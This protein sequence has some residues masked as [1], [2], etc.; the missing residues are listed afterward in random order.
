MNIFEQKPDLNNIVCHS[1]GATGADTYFETLGEIWGVKTHA[2]SYKTD[3]HTSKNK[4]EI[5]Q[6]DFE[7]GIEEI[8]KANKTLARFGIHKYMNLLARNWAQIK[9]SKQVFAI[10]EIINPRQKTSRGYYSK[11]RH[12]TVDGGTGYAVQMAIN[13][14]REV[15]VYCQRVK[16]WH[17]WSYPSMSF[18][19]LS[20]CP[21]I[22]TNNFAGIGT[23]QI[24]SDGISAITDLYKKTFETTSES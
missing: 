23:R 3:Y 1:G 7:E 4:V 5:S 12:Q 22:T 19:K 13:H 24:N 20:E 6:S 14:H 18:V 10:G 17:K 16:S 21:K 2:Y 9:Y 11:S 8:N 15:F